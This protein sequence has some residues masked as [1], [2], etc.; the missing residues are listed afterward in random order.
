MNKIFEDML[1]ACVLEFQGKWED[2]LPL[3]EFSYNNNYQL[4]IKM[5][6]FKALHR[7]KCITLL[8]WSNLDEAVTLDPEL[9]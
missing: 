7:R 1:R 6:P 2:D 3:L 8:C 9:I 4:T 5:A